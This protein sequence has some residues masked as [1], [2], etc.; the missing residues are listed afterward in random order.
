[1]NESPQADREPTSQLRKPGTP[2]RVLRW[3]VGVFGG[4]LAALMLI[5]GILVIMAIPIDLSVARERVETLA[6]NALKRPFSIEGSM[7]LFP[8]LPP[9]LQVEGVRIGNPAGWPDADLLKLQRARVRVA[10][11]PLLFDQVQMDELTVDGLDLQ[12]ETSAAGEANWLTE[13]SKKPADV[14]AERV[15]PV[16]PSLELGQLAL[17]D[18]RITHKDAAEG[19]S[20]ELTFGEVTGTA[21]HKQP[22][23]LF[24]EGSIQQLPYR[25]TLEGDS[26][27]KLLE[28]DSPWR[29][30][31]SIETRGASARLAG[32]L[33][34]P[35]QTQGFHLDLDL[36]VPTPKPLS[37]VL[38]LA[39]RH[40]IPWPLEAGSEERRVATA[41]RN[42]K[43]SWGSPI[44]RGICQ[45]IPR[46]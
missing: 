40:P 11:F 39:C 42:L 36:Q 38:G 37:R 35:L 33:E 8:T 3:V 10:I 24:L 14:K 13:Q 20:R 22:L 7:T 28:G 21:Q 12:L 41:W 44:L 4:L 17:R 18:V 34:K 27:A 29:L 15:T 23:Q 5:V 9:T 16:S 19:E 2:T 32:T 6:S 25:A 43:V 45:S 30:D 46:G 31:L 26:L 1:M